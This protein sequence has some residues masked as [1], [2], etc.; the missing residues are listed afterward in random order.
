[1][2][3]FRNITSIIEKR[4]R[5]VLLKKFTRGDKSA[6]MALKRTAGQRM[7]FDESGNLN[8]RIFLKVTS[9]PLQVKFVSEPA[10][11]R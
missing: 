3:C 6:N 4:G 9:L 1:M 8:A 7:N 10:G 11:K 5:I 2:I